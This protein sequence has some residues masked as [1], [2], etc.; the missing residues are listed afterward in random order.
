MVQLVVPRFLIP[1]LAVVASV[2][3]ACSEHLPDP[4]GSPPSSASTPSITLRSTCAVPGTPPTGLETTEVLANV[5]F[6]VGVTL[7]PIPGA[8]YAHTLDGTVYLWEPPRAP[9]VALSIADHVFVGDA[10]AGLFSVLPAPASRFAAR[11]E[12]FLAYTEKT[13]DGHRSVVT[14]A[15]SPDGG[16]TFDPTSERVVLAVPRDQPGHNGGALAFL[17][18]GTLLTT[19][20]DGSWGDPDRRAQNPQE[21]FG[22][23]LRLDVFGGEPYASPPDNPFAGGGGRPEVWALGFRN[24]YRLSVDLPTGNVWVGDVGQH[25]WEEVN[26]VEAGKNYGWPL[27]EGPDCYAE[28]PCEGDFEPP[29]HAYRHDEGL[30]V[31]GG[32]VYRGKAMPDLVGHY[33]FADLVV[34]TL[35]ATAPDGGTRWLARLPTLATQLAPDW[36]GEPLVADLAQG[37]LLRIVPATAPPAPPPALLSQTGCVDPRD[38]TRPAAGMFTYDV[39]VPLW[40]DGADKTR[41]LALPEGGTLG[42]LEDGRLE[43]PVGGVLTK[44]FARDGRPIETRFVARRTASDWVFLTYRFRDD[45]SDAELVGDEG[46]DAVLPSGPWAFPSRAQCQGCHNT[47]GGPTLSLELRQLDRAWPAGSVAENQLDALVRLRAFHGELPSPRPRPLDALGADTEIDWRARS[48][49]H[50]N[51]SNCHRP[52]W[53]GRNQMDLRIDTSFH[54]TDVCNVVSGGADPTF[55]LVRLAP[56]A[57]ERSLLHVR[58]AKVGDQQMPPFGRL[59]VD[60]AAVGVLQD[61]IRGLADLDCG[62]PRYAGRE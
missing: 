28:R 19:L 54:D 12:L 34:G 22:K 56:G 2:F 31:I 46:A 42:V 45:G 58:A 49:L 16:R 44:H 9:V 57:P 25:T 7:A 38:V 30:S 4:Y 43:L 36:D 8:Y 26:L 32:F 33:L 48:Y 27:R 47:G 53:L 29:V 40:S 23:V 60:D 39:N 10:E 55:S 21:L 6:L 52:A 14:R 17:A 51:C 62:E 11:P 20:G 15:T 24:P 59:R 3:A 37:R 61:W 50:V 18:D 13:A 41:A 5:P 1:L 35:W